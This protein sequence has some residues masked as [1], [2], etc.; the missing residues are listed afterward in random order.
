MQDYRA[1]LKAKL[2]EAFTDDP[3][4]C[5]AYNHDLSEMPAILLMLFKRTPA[6]VALPRS[7]E[8]VCT[9]LE[10]A[11]KHGVP[12]T[13]RAQASSGYGGAMP[14]C[15]GLLV[16]MSQ[17]KRILGVDRE[18]MTCD[19]E[20]GVVWNDLDFELAKSGLASRI[21][22][23]S[24]LSSTVGGMFA[25]GGVGIGSF[26]YGSIL[27]CVEEIDVV[28]PNGKM[29]T[30]RGAEL[31][32][33][34]FSQ[35]TL[36]IVVRLRLKLRANSPL[37]KAAF[38]LGS[39]HQAG[40]VVDE[41]KKLSAY[42]VSILSASYLCMQAEAAV[43]P[44][45]SPIASGFFLLAV[46]EED[47]GEDVLAGFARR[48]GLARLSDEA[49]E[50]EWNV[51][52]YPMRIKRNAPALLASE[53]VVPSAK[54]GAVCDELAAKMKRDCPG[55]E[56]FVDRDGNV[57]ALVYLQDSAEDI[58]SLC[59]MGK[60]MEPLHVASKH[61]GWV[62]ASGLWFNSQSAAIL[63]RERM[64]A[65]KE[66]KL[67]LDP[68]NR[69]NPGKCVGHGLRFLPFQLLSWGIWIGT[70]VIAPLSRMLK[71]RPRRIAGHEE[72]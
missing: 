64:T 13:P 50:H 20:P 9:A 1:E 44:Q 69:M 54:F 27:D 60:A 51:R 55:Y 11:Y 59:R 16:D 66:R 68:K 72:D 2:G 57:A 34:A 30:V 25:M 28:D 71:C 43:P 36:G 26:R 19:V 40:P 48:L 67:A 21:C 62:Y 17:M 35:G 4:I 8:D 33:Y 58:L 32:V 18:A 70:I 65:L 7:A 47:P 56:A 39:A 52:Y 15:G 49:A 46:F 22:P 45:T 41:L 38:R 3:Q 12:V 24:G 5:R 14:A 10:A 31:A 37:K 53:F 29:R 42:S 63:G 61:G 6:A 23:T